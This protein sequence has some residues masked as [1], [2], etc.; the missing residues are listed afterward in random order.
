MI[1]LISPAKKLDFSPIDS[2]LTNTEPI[3]LTQTEKLVKKLK[4]LKSSDISKLMKLSPALS[5]LNFERNQKF[6]HTDNEYKQAVFSFNGE[7]Y[8]GLDAK[9]M[10]SE[11]LNY[12]NQKLRILS[13]LYGILK[14]SDLIQPY[15]LEM[16]TKLKVGRANNL[17]EFWGETILKELN[18]T[19][20]SIIVNLASNE[21]IKAAKL[22]S[23]NG[24]VI[25]PT[26]KDFKNGEYKTIMMYAKKARGS[27]SRWIIDNK[28]ENIEDL[29]GFNIDNYFYSTELSEGNNW[30]FTR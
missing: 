11:S 24:K 12:A 23:F 4:K 19:S 6:D 16:G 1:I 20:S 28:I 13:G 15:R 27:M 10:S 2:T 8:S 29:K 17:Y 3:F 22:L 18:S 9:T 26:F 5:N 14:P 30:V 25:T 7:V 21:Y